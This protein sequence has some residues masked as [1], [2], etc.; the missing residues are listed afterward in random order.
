MK[1]LKKSNLEMLCLG[2]LGI[3]IATRVLFSLLPAKPSLQKRLV[4]ELM[5]R[6][7]PKEESVQE[8]EYE[9]LKNRFKPK[10]GAIRATAY[11]WEVDKAIIGYREKVE[12]KEA[13]ISIP[14]VLLFYA[15][16]RKEAKLPAI[17]VRDAGLDGLNE[18][19]YPISIEKSRKYVTIKKIPTHR[20][21][22]LKE[23]I[24]PKKGAISCLEE[25]NETVVRERY[26]KEK[27]KI[28]QLGDLVNKD[29]WSFDEEV[30]INVEKGFITREERRT[31][32]RLYNQQIEE[33]IKDIQNRY[34]PVPKEKELSPK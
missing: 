30:I 20:I 17:K 11:K 5:K 23:Y 32:N 25:D 22:N 10:E 13:S 2:I 14:S 16:E 24:T 4:N 12:N 21:S 33:T 3:A 19:V 26:D 9:D 8:F 27:D 29:G 15:P 1:N 18:R 28:Y 31:V 34:A 6:D 7:I